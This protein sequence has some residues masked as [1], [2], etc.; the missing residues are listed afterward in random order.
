MF[1]VML[2]NALWASTFTI[3]KFALEFIPPI[4][5]VAVRMILAGVIL[6]GYQY[7][8]NRS[9]WKFNRQDLWAFF[10]ISIYFM[11]FAFVTEF[12]ALQDVT[13]AKAC[14]LFNLSPFMTA[15][16][17]H[18]M[19]SEKITRRQL[20]GLVIGFI[21]F[22]PIIIS[23]SGAEATA[24]HFGVFSVPEILLIASVIFSSYGWILIKR[25]IVLRK[26]STVMV[27]GISM[28]IGGIASLIT[29]LLIEG[30]PHYYIAS[31]GHFG[32]SPAQYSFL[33]ATIYMVLTILVA[34]IICF[35]LQSDLMRYYS[36]TFITFTGFTAPLFAAFF[37]WLFFGI[38]ASTAFFITVAFVITGLYLYY[39]DEF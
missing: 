15:I 12:W 10:Q 17:A 28:L 30:K 33:M 39:Q 6:L 18:F 37:D 29:S 36:V 8:F 25:L 32:F 21:G 31:V 3:G 11:Y 20:L 14:L 35:N 34:H 1:L 16:F 9:Q 4:L 2:L 27:N 26:Y 19:L 24:V 7:L 23:Q 38:I 5:Y 13:A 22:A